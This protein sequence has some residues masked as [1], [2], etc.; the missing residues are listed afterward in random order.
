[1]PIQF[2]TDISIPSGI[3]IS[4]ESLEAPIVRSNQEPSTI[5]TLAT[6]S[7]SQPGLCQWLTDLI[8][9]ILSWFFPS[10]EPISEEPINSPLSTDP[11]PENT[12]EEP[13][14]YFIPTSPQRPTISSSPASP[15]INLEQRI[16]EAKRVIDEQLFQNNLRFADQSIPQNQ[17][18]VI[19]RLK[20]NDQETAFAKNWSDPD[21]RQ[22]VENKTE[23]FLSN[24]TNI[25][26]SEGDLKIKSIFFQKFSNGFCINFFEPSSQISFPNRVTTHDVT[27]E[28]MQ[29]AAFF[30]GSLVTHFSHNPFERTTI[31]DL[32][33][34]IPSS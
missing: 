18:G 4:P 33:R 15:S 5:S 24:A 6:P 13:I 28:R 12:V 19:V 20:Y 30:N 26:Q 22:F 10:S 32:V 23:A 11:T 7:T 27:S 2:P 3:Q 14:N 29:S 8:Q 17:W 9:R 21:V 31:Q 1:M 34:S 25:D 16:T